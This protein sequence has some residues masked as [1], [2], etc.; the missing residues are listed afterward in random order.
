MCDECV[1]AGRMTEQEAAE[2]RKELTNALSLLLGGLPSG[3]D[4]ESAAQEAADDFLGTILGLGYTLGF[5]KGD[6]GKIVLGL[7]PAG[8]MPGAPARGISIAD[9]DAEQIRELLD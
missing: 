4:R 9:W 5:R 2:Q 6:G 3:N 8:T 7:I 1:S